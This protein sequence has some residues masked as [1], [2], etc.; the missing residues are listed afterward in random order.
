MN[1]F[2]KFLDEIIL[3]VIK[4]IGWAILIISFMNPGYDQSILGVLLLIYAKLVEVHVK[5]K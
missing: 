4:F 5:Q 2:L 1:K 3:G